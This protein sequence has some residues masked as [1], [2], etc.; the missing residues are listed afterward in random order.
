VDEHQ[1]D[2]SKFNKVIFFTFLGIAA[3]LL[4]FFVY[5]AL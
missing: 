2:D 3:I 5:G 4:G 1:H